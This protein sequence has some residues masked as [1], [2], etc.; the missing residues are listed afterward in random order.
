M[1]QPQIVMTQLLDFT[2]K[3]TTK[4]VTKPRG[5]ALGVGD[6]H[7]YL[8][9]DA[10]RGLWTWPPCLA[11]R[12]L[13]AAAASS[14]WC[15]SLWTGRRKPACPTGPPLRGSAASIT[16]RTQKRKLP[17][18]FTHEK[19]FTF[20]EYLL[21]PEILKGKKKDAVSFSSN[22]SNLYVHTGG[23]RGHWPHAPL[24]TCR[25]PG[26]AAAVHK[27]QSRVKHTPKQKSSLL[28]SGRSQRGHTE[29]SVCRTEISEEKKLCGGQSAE[30]IQHHP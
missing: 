4:R 10:W 19:S 6:R 8:P 16:P 15:G 27:W 7:F 25:C 1:D 12:S 30:P 29:I 23:V 17:H 21:H 2:L 3:K 28:V 26:W 14:R 11:C 5:G 24:S 20:T 18:Q 22:I 13:W 9:S